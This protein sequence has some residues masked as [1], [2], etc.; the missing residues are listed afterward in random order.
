MI[1]KEKGITETGVAG[2][3]GADGKE[4]LMMIKEDEKRPPT[5]KTMN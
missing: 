4:A 2:S 1:G 5:V 3:T